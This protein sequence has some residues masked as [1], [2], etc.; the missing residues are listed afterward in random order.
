[1]T[2]EEIVRK[3]TKAQ[4]E[5]LTT[6]AE[7]LRPAHWGSKQWM[8]FPPKNTHDVLMRHGLVKRSGKITAVGRVIR[9][10][11]LENTHD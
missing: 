5:Y 7:F 1:M 6:K 3:L 8:T 4:R 10:R 2:A 11:L 9:R